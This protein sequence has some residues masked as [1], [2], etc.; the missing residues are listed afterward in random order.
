MGGGEGHSELTTLWTVVVIPRAPWLS[1]LACPQWICVLD[2]LGF[3]IFSFLS[4]PEWDLRKSH[5]WL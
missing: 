2:W 3:M 1:C 4:W 5:K